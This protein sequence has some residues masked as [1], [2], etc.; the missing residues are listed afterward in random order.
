[1]IGRHSVETWTVKN[2]INAVNVR[3]DKYRLR[4]VICYHNPSL[5]EQIGQ[6]G[7]IDS[8]SRCFRSLGI[9]LHERFPRAVHKEKANLQRTTA[10]SLH[11]SSFA[12]LRRDHKPALLHFLTSE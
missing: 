10:A 7:Q 9:G 12:G 8:L 6:A 1:M 3:A 11:R 4:I 5:I 2:Q